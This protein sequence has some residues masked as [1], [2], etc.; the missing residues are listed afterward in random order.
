MGLIIDRLGKPGEDYLLE[1]TNG[2]DI[3]VVN[4]AVEALGRFPQSDGTKARLTQLSE[5]HPNEALREHALR[6]LLNQSD[7]PKLAEHAWSLHAFDDGFR[8]M[9][10]EW[11]AKHD[12]DKARSTALQVLAGKEDDPIRIAS[13]QAL[14]VVKGDQT[15]CD[16][17]LKVATENSYRARLTAIRALGSLGNP[18]AIPVLEGFSKYE[19]GAVVGTASQVLERLKSSQ[20]GSSQR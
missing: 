10:M 18:A 5:T 1:L 12:P 13:C 15:V 20:G 16:A 3:R 2:K 9:A 17:L 7:D 6:S 19:P 11:W 8:V 4:S 14:G